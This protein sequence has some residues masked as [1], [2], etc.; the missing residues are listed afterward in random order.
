MVFLPATYTISLENMRFRAPI[1]VCCDE[2]NIG[3]DIIIAISAE[4]NA[5]TKAFIEDELAGAPDYSIVYKRIAHLV[6][7]PVRL[8]EHLAYKVACETLDAAH[9]FISVKVTITKIN[10]PVSSDGLKATVELC[11]TRQLFESK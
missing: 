7:Q 6:R 5:S 2:R 1:G 11:I 8:L 9:E 10:P 4:T 3:T